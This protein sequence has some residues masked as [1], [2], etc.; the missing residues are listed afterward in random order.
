MKARADRGAIDEILSCFDK[1]KTIELAVAS[2]PNESIAE[3]RESQKIREKR[4]QL[5]SEIMQLRGMLNHK[6]YGA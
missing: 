2:L 5:R 4:E 1:I 3:W 6:M